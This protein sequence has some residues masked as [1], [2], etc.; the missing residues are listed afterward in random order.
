MNFNLSTDPRFLV[1]FARCMRRGTVF[2]A[3]IFGA[4][5]AASAAGRTPHGPDHPASIT[6]PAQGTMEVAFSPNEGAESLVIKVIDSARSE[7][8]VMAYSFTSVPVVEALLR[9]RHRPGHAVD[10]QVVVDAKENL[11]SRNAI[12]AMNALVNAGVVVRTIDVYPIAH[13]KV[14]VADRSTV[15]LGSYN[16]SG[17]A[18]HSNS[19]NVL[20]VWG[21]PPLAA[22]YLRHFDRN[23]N[24]SKAYTPAY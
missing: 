19:E 21:S 23:F 2:A 1:L 4:S 3:L 11:R 6:M 8:R 22:A 14:I 20:V 24:L 7:L 18:A 17:A 5:L 9:A 15:E 13:D 16:Y 12:A 10:V